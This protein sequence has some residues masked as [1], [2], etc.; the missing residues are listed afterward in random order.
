M[1]EKCNTD[2]VFDFSPISPKQIAC[3]AGREEIGKALS[4][5]KKVQPQNMAIQVSLSRKN[6]VVM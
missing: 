6:K 3:W 2:Y 1:A 5:D 4:S